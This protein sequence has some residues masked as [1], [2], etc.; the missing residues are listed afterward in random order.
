MSS[1]NVPH[2]KITVLLLRASS[3]L[4]INQLRT[5]IE[6]SSKLLLLLRAAP[7][8]INDLLTFVSILHQ[9]TPYIHTTHKQ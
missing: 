9:P 1:P 7:T 4:F 8:F 2:H 5:K 3:S 6:T